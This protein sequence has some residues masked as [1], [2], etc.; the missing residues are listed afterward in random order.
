MGA[1]ERRR[2]T[3]LRRETHT[4]EGALFSLIRVSTARN[5]AR[6][7]ASVAEIGDTWG[8]AIRGDGWRTYA[9]R[10]PYLLSTSPPEDS[11]TRGGTL[12]YA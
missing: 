4:R 9:L 11:V 7:D 1:L 10:A 8:P 12:T 2:D 6:D 3:A 5:G